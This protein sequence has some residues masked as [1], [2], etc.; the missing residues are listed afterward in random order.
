V[1][2]RMRR[3]PLADVALIAAIPSGH[4]D[5]AS[6]L[7]NQHTRIA[8]Q[9]HP[10][11]GVLRPAAI[12]Y[13]KSFRSGSRMARRS[14]SVLGRIMTTHVSATL[15]NGLFKPDES[16]PLA[17]QTRVRLTIE[18]IADQS[19]ETAVAAWEAIQAR[20]KERPIRGATMRFTRDELHERR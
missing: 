9:R 10:P 3:L 6:G 8:G 19:A 5:P 4:A 1:T 7:E 11:H 2:L 14:T 16:I 18:P 12:Q 13:V 20:L 17:D 15:I